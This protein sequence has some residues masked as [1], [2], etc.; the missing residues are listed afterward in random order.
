MLFAMSLMTNTESSILV[1]MYLVLNFQLFLYK[2]IKA[3]KKNTVALENILWS[4]YCVL[5]FLV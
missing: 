4:A 2:F 1:L 5:I 3:T